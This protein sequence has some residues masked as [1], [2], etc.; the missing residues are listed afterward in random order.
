MLCAILGAL[1]CAFQIVCAKT[2][3][4]LTRKNGGG[5]VQTSAEVKNS[6]AL[7]PDF[8]SID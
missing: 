3:C 6:P 4:G 8:R 5:N 2:K 7:L 1:G